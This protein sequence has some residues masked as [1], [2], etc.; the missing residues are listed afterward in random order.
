MANIVAGAKPDVT[1]SLDQLHS[2]RGGLVTAFRSSMSRSEYFAALCVLGCINGIGSRA[3]QAIASYGLVEATF[4][5]FDVSALVWIAGAIAVGL[6][7]EDHGD[8]I[9][10]IDMAVGAVFLV[11]VALPIAA[12]SWFGL[13]A[14]GLYL[15]L[16]AGAATSR[17]RGAK[18]LIAMT[19]PMLWSRLLF[20]FFSEF[21]LH[22][23]ASLVGRTLGTATAGNVVR[24]ADGSGDLVILPAC[25]SLAGLSLVVLCWVTLSQTVQHP[26]SMRDVVWC[27]LA[28]I[29]VVAVNVTRI[30]VM[31]LSG[32]HYEMLHGA[33]GNFATN[34]MTLCLVAGFCMLGARRELFARA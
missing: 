19:I 29:S 13:T 30:S 17:R 22:I 34:T 15:V 5:T 8:R 7:L 26:W 27:A 20:R 14:L 1:A 32:A 31:G 3:I 23:D 10:T 18:I 28:S 6:L 11:L 12:A 16:V 21:I 24:F 33:W 25:S 9:T 2:R 4:S